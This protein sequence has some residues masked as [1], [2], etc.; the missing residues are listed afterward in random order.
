MG[1]WKPGDKA[2]V[3]PDTVPEEWRWYPDASGRRVDVPLDREFKVLY[4]DGDFI[5]IELDAYVGGFRV[6]LNHLIRVEVTCHCPID[7][8][9]SSGCR[10]GGK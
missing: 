4:L 9:M 6:S 3:N 5:V 10:C 1:T 2:R 7:V 8:L